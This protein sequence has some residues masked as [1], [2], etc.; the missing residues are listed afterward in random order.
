[1]NEKCLYPSWVLNKERY[2]LSHGFPEC[3]DRVERNPRTRWGTRR[4]VR[5][6]PESFLPP[7]WVDTSGSKPHLFLAWY[8]LTLEGSKLCVCVADSVLTRSLPGETI[9]V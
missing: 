1:V 7:G 5:Q 4:E 3:V 8:S 9:Y 6:G 2:S